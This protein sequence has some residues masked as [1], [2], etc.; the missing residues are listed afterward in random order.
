[1]NTTYNPDTNRAT[2]ADLLTHNWWLL[3]L[4]GL[5][6]V[7]FGVLAF[8]WPG[9]TLLTLLFLFGAFALLNGVLAFVAAL[10]APK[11]YPRFGSLILE[12]ILSVAAG[13]IALFVPGITALALLILIASWAIVSG[14][15]EIVAAIR[16]RKVIRHEWTL[17]LA[18]LASIAFGVIMIVQPAVG[19]LALVW[20][21][22][23][24]MFAF[25]ILLIALAFRLRRW[26]GP[27]TT[28]EAATT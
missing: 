15:F 23:A 26:R 27:S 10:R 8:V 7:A 16:L 4:R 28:T 14:F 21:I 5:A 22:G 25:G 13:A 12:G 19:A 1:M 3:A 17:A 18:G 2:V 20:W 24:F 9:I 11:G 6:A